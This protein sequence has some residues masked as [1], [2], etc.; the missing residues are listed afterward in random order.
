MDSTRPPGVPSLDGRGGSLRWMRSTESPEESVEALREE[1]RVVREEQV[2]LME[3]YEALEKDMAKE[4]E[5]ALEEQEGKLAEANS[6]IKVMEKELAAQGTEAAQLQ[7]QVGQLE[8]RVEEA[9]NEAEKFLSGNYGLSDAVYDAKLLKERL[10]GADRE[11]QRRVEEVN[12]YASKLDEALEENLWLKRKAG[13]PEDISIDL[14]DVRLVRQ[15]Q[16]M[17]VKAMNAMLEEENMRLEEDVRRLKHEVRF[18]TKWEG[19]NAAGR[20]GAPPPTCRL[21]PICPSGLQ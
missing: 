4:V 13:L 17:Q 19:M 8:Q 5:K 18:R 9:E 12:T 6:L 1:L 2:L 16:M 14:K 7:E 21:L 11:V 10:R 3:A 15:G 20:T